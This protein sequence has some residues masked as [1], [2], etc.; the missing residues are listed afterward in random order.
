MTSAVCWLLFEVRP[1]AVE[2]LTALNLRFVDGRLLVDEAYRN[3]ANVFADVCRLLMTAWR[4]NR[5]VSNRFAAA[6]MTGNQ[7]TAAEYLG[8]NNMMNQLLNDGSVG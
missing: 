6:C 2:A 3:V 4:A 5:V 8:V 1:E 7:M